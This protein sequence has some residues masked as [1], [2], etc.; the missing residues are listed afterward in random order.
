[1]IPVLFLLITSIWIPV[2]DSYENIPVKYHTIDQCGGY[3][4]QKQLILGCYSDSNESIHQIELNPDHVFDPAYL[5]Y[6]VWTHEVLH[7]WGFS[8]AEMEQ[9][10]VNALP[11]H[12]IPS[13]RTGFVS[14]GGH[15]FER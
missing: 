10:F 9:L 2:G 7:A 15:I 6:N 4:S 1:M 11:K 14:V 13:N 3:H 5:G 8:H 12:E